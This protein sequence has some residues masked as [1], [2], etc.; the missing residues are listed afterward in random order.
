MIILKAKNRSTNTSEIGEI[1]A[2]A[3][4][5][6]FSPKSIVIDYASFIKVYNETGETGVISLDIDGEKCNVLV[7]E[8]KMEPVK[9]TVAHVDFYVPEAGK[10]VHA[11]IPLDFIGES[12]AVKQGNILIKVMH[13]ISVEALPENLPHDIKVD[14]SKLET[15][16]D[17]VTVADLIFPANVK[18]LEEN[19]E[20]VASVVAPKEEKEEVV[21]DLAAI[22]VEKK[23]KKEE[24]VKE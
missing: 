18:S 7:H 22:E 16:S 12:A 14:I 9:N 15:L 10:K 17:D 2:V 5:P 23:G 3:Y 6:K 8:I 20:V 19:S 11:N 13:E 4:G 24:E 1:K 21:V